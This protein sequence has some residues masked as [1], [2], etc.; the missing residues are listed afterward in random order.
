MAGYMRPSAAFMGRFWIIIIMNW[1]FMHTQ[2]AYH[3]FVSQA[4]FVDP[5]MFSL[6]V[7]QNA[8]RASPVQGSE[9][10]LFAW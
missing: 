4:R 2:G 1:E 8:A 3:M 10:I 9:K 7:E 5:L 6:A